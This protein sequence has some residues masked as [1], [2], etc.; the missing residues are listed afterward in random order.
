MSLAG[1]LGWARVLIFDR[2]VLDVAN[3]ERS[4][5]FYTE[6]LDFQSVSAGD[7]LGHQTRLLQLGAFHLL[8]LEQPGTTNP[9][10]LPKAGPLMTLSEA[11]IDDLF[12]G[13][14]RADVEIV[15]PLR[16]SPWGSRSFLMR[17]PDGYLLIVQE[18]PFA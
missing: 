4:V 7:W 17:D 1:E 3:L 6:L 14:E 13:L 12:E 15:S 8:L 5:R 2:L 18:P 11:R 9:L 16:D 10:N